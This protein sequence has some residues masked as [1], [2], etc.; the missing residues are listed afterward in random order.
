MKNID[1]ILLEYINNSLEKVYK[2][3]YH[4]ILNRSL[5]TNHTNDNHHVGERSIVFRFAHY[6][7]NYIDKD[8]LFNEY[9]LDCEYN[10]NGAECKRLPSFPNGVY[11]DVIIH[12]RGSNEKNLA[13]IEFKT[14]WNSNISND[15]RK[16]I[17]L[18]DKAG[19]YKYYREYVVVLQK[20]FKDIIIN[21]Y[22]GD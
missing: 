2:D 3:D 7:L 19:K 10:R 17:E 13:I 15:E 16:I 5:E 22:K 6:L 20:D 11:P 18:I 1:E 9:D 4:L 21:T 14:Y 8:E 12:K